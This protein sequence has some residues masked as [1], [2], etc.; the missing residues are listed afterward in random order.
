VAIVWCL[1][2]CVCER[3]VGVIRWRGEGVD[4]IGVNKADP[5][6]VLVRV[7][8]QYFRPTEVLLCDD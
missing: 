1:C 5:E 2:P 6:H 3:G 4:E 7:D 8:P